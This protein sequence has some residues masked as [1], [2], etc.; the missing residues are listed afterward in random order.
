VPTATS[1]LITGGTTYGTTVDAG[2]A[3]SFT[4]FPPTP[5]GWTVTDATDDQ[6]FTISLVDNISRNYA[7][8]IK[9]ISTGAT[10]ASFTLDQSGSGSITYSDG[11]TASITTWILSQ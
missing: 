4:I 5:T 3:A 1:L 8:T 2:S 11:T 10:L 7:G 6:I 9:R